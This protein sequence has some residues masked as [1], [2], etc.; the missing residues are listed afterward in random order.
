MNNLNITII[1]GNL[2]GD[3]RTREAGKAMATG[4]TVAVHCSFPAGDGESDKREYADRTDFID[5]E[6]WK[7]GFAQIAESRLRKGAFVRVQ[8]RLR[9]DSWH[10]E[11]G[12]Q[13]SRV[14]VVADKVD[15]GPDKAKGQAS[16]AGEE[17]AE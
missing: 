4:F 15:F 14:V 6:C 8:G 10:G 17:E 2:T 5:C 16:G 12:R 11:D 1:E 3:C 13:R 7:P 9:Q